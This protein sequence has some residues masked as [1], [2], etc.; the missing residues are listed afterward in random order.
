MSL[1]AFLVDDLDGL[2]DGA[3]EQGAELDF[4][5]EWLLVGGGNGVQVEVSD[6]VEGPMEAQLSV[7][8]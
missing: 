7:L 1:F 6:G 2:F 3:K 4:L 8:L 5:E